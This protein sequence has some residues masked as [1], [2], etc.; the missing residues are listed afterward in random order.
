MILLALALAQTAAP[1]ARAQD[2]VVIGQRLK[3]WRASWRSRKGKVSC[4]IKQSSG[5]REV[6]AIGCA[7][8]TEC[9]API[10]PRALALA[11]DK[12][13]TADARKRAQE[14]INSDMGRCMI[15]RRDT[16]IV[17]LA[18]RRAAARAAADT[19]S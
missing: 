2:V 4:A 6:D 14:A 19:G 7:A 16:L 11:K 5:D 17:E 10:E 9:A 18:D 8:M 1:D 13:M 3:T 15:A 12:T